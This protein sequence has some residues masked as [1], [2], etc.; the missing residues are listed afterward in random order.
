MNKPRRQP[1]RNFGRLYEK[2]LYDYL[3]PTR[4]FLI[5][6]AEKDRFSKMDFNDKNGRRYELKSRRYNKKDFDKLGHM[7]E[8]SKIDYIKINPHRKVK[9]YYLY[10]DGLY[11]YDAN[12]DK[13]GEGIHLGHGG[14]MDRGEDE[15]KEQAYINGKYLKFITNKIS[16]E[17]IFDKCI[18]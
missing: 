11:C 17:N 2:K 14:R 3:R 12:R 4:P 18:L 16:V 7:I 1:D 13:L 10:Y 6:N 15:T 9:I 8:K 5:W